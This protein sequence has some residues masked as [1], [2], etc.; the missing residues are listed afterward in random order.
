[1]LTEDNE[2]ASYLSKAYEAGTDCG[3]SNEVYAKYAGM[4]H[5]IHATDTWKGPSE[6]A[7]T[8]AEVMDPSGRSEDVVVLDF[9]AGTGL[10]GIAM[11]KHGFSTIDAIDISKEMLEVAQKEYQGG[12]YRKLYCGFLEKDIHLDADSYHMIIGA[13]I[14]GTHVGTD[15]VER[16]M[17]LVKPGGRILYTIRVEA[18]ESEEFQKFYSSFCDE[19]KSNGEWNKEYSVDKGPLNLDIPSVN[20]RIVSIKRADTI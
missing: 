4:Y 5:E 3:K 17:K 9:G 15:E 7:K 1:M 12:L 10:S 6:L 13:G 11:K 19:S 8:A 16:L 14:I 18:D 20:H 2:K